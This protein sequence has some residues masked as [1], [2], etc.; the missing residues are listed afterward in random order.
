[1]KLNIVGTRLVAATLIA[2]VVLHYA[3]WDGSFWRHANAVLAPVATI[4][5]AVKLGV[6]GR[7]VIQSL[8]DFVS[9]AD[10]PAVG[11]LVIQH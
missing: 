9:I 3:T 11:V 8:P 2:V 6:N 1:M 5:G 7:P 4:T 10:K